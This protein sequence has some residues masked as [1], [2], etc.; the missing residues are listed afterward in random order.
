MRRQRGDPAGALLAAGRGAAGDGVALGDVQAVDLQAPRHA[1]RAAVE[2]VVE[3]VAPPPEA[4]REQHSGRRRVGEHDQRDALAAAADPRTERAERDRAPD[5]QP[6]VPDLDRV[7]RAGARL[8]VEVQLGV[9]HHVVEPAADD[10]EHDRPARDV[11][12]VLARAAPLAHP[13]RREPQREEDARHDAQRVRTDRDRAQ[14]PHALRRAGQEGDRM[15]ASNRS[16]R[17]FR[18]MADTSVD[19]VDSCPCRSRARWTGRARRCSRGPVPDPGPASCCIEVA[20][21]GVNFID[22]YQRTGVYPIPTP[23]VLGG[24]AAGRVIA[25]GEGVTDLRG[26][27]PRRHRRTRAERWPKRWRSRPTGSCPVPDGVD[28]E[29]AAAAMLQ[30]MTAHYLVNS[31]YAVRDG[32]RGADPRCRRRCRPAARPAGQGE[33]RPRG[34]HRGR[35]GEGADRPRPR[36]RRGDP[37]RP[38]RR[39]RRRG[40][41]SLERRRARRLRRCRQGHLRRL[42]G[43]RC[44]RA[45]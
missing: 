18:D 24:E 40:A 42:A 3:P 10:A 27:R 26:R 22:V 20:A 36:C 1:G 15:H 14:M 19:Q 44:A 23:F 11:P 25:V 45:A 21:A 29:V 28:A 30:G 8:A 39:P 5:A 4:L 41:R 9:G 33:G 43:R 32:R 7:E 38:G 2:L 37:L 13:P 34:G 35:A 12:D 16:R 31:T 6:A 17:T